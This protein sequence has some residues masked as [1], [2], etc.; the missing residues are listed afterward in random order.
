MYIGTGRPS[1]EETRKFR[2]QLIGFLSP[3]EKFDARTFCDKVMLCLH[4]SPGKKTAMVGGT[5]F[6]L[7]ALLN[8]LPAH[9]SVSEEIRNHYQNHY[10]TRGLAYLLEKLKKLDKEYYEIV[11][12]KN[13]RRILR[14]LEVIES[15]GE[16]FSTLRSRRNSTHICPLIFV[17]FLRRKKLYWRIDRR[18]EKMITSNLIE[19]VNALLNKGYSPD[20]P[21]LNTIGYKEIVAHLR[22][23]YSKN[24]AI[25]LIKQNTRHYAKR[26][27]TWFKKFPGAI[28]LLWDSPGDDPR[29]AWVKKFPILEKKK[30]IRYNGGHRNE[31]SM[32]I[33]RPTVNTLKN[34]IKSFY[35]T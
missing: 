16:K 22:G 29:D 17:N 19:E 14:A 26:Q 12:K 20:S 30:E 31:S 5:A 18:I 4:Q 6:Y 35:G 9:S 28:H 21:G 8:G 7:E 32:C 15:T 24:Q 13:P 34:L 10:H 1:E 2:Y 25:D 3:D 33:H 27:I 23:K 11:D